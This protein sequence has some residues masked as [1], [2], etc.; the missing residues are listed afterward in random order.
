MS[1]YPDVQA[2]ARKEIKQFFTDGRPPNFEYQD[3]MPYVEAVVLEGL[4]W[5][6]PGSFG[7][8]HSSR[9]DDIYN[10]HFIPKGTTVIPNL[11]YDILPW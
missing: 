2:R 7:V 9:E 1:L 8:P 10:G 6:P 3:Q 4:R 11:W 5:N